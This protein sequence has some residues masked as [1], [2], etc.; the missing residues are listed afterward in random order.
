MSNTGV[1]G[2]ATTTTFAAVASAPAGWYDIGS[3]RRRWFDG[4]GWTDHYAPMPPETAAASSRRTPA[5]HGFHLIMTVMTL[6]AW[7]PVWGIAAGWSAA[8]RTP[9]RLI[10]S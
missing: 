10:R 1:V 4:R 2:Q 6:C 7:L 9:H 5:D 3:G 8:R